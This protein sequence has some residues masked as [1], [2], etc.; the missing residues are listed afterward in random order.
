MLK[1]LESQLRHVYGREEEGVGV[2]KCVCGLMS[3]MHKAELAS[4]GR[5]LENE[6]FRVRIGQLGKRSWAFPL[7]FPFI[8]F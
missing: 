5:S 6:P 8:I 3:G 2:R 1:C 7:L 4:H